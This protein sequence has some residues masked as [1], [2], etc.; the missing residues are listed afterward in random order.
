[1][2]GGLPPLLRATFAYPRPGKYVEELK[3]VFRCGYLFDA[4]TTSLWF[5]ARFLQ[6]PVVRSRDELKRFLSV[7]PLGFMMMPEDEAS[8][9][10][11]VR[12][13][14]LAGGTLPL[15][16]PTFEEVATAMR[17]NEQTLRRRLKQELTSY[18][19]IKEYIRRDLAIQKLM[20]SRQ[21]VQ[22]IA[23]LLGYSEPRAFTRAFQQ[24]TGSSPIQYRTRLHQQFRP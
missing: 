17:T 19:T 14:L 24:W 21:P 16:F 3:H 1:M 4:P 6:Q 13:M 7:A 20:E 2:G 9:S 15:N 18:R 10:R 22:E 12:S 8:L 5:D 11:R 23:Y